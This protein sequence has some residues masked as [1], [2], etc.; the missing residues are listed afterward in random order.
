MMRSPEDEAHWIIELSQGNA[1][2]ALQSLSSQFQVLQSRSQ[3]LLTV[4]TLTLTI[5]GFSG[6]VIARS[7]KIAGVGLAVGLVLV[8]SSTILLLV[9]SLR[10]KWVSQFEGENLKSILT[11]IIAYR[12]QKTALF[13]WELLLLVLG[14]S[15]YV[16]SLV[17]YLLKN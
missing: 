13:G 6:P 15:C 4:T 16:G 1:S 14:L 5:T 12:N 10:L 9:G 8:L 2:E 11:Q 17:I 3:L 7:H